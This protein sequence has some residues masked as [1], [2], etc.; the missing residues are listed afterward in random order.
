MNDTDSLQKQ[1][2]AW[3][4]QVDCEVKFSSFLCVS[5]RAVRRCQVQLRDAISMPSGSRGI[6]N[7]AFL[8]FLCLNRCRAAKIIFG[9]YVITCNYMQ[10]LSVIERTSSEFSLHKFFPTYPEKWMVKLRM[11]SLTINRATEVRC[12]ITEFLTTIRTS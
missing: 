11:P 7:I 4:H 1:L 12:I 3:K 10:N 6:G 5:R 9:N 8:T 2:P